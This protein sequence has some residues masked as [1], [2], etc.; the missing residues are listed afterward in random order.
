MKMTKDFVDVVFLRRRSRWPRVYA[1]WASDEAAKRSAGRRRRLFIYFYALMFGGVL[2]IAVAADLVLSLVTGF[3]LSLTIPYD[4]VDGQWILDD[5][6]AGEWIHMVFLLVVMGCFVRYAR[7]RQPPPAPGPIFK[8][9]MWLIAVF[10]AISLCF[11][12]IF[13]LLYYLFA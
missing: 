6:I 3:V 1:L 2:A 8:M 10:F 7:P 12:V 13:S 5:I 9:M 4:F 11:S